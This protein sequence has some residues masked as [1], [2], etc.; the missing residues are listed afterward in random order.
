M[1]LCRS[2]RK[3]LQVLKLN[4][5]NKGVLDQYSDLRP[6]IWKSTRYFFM[7]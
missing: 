1:D 2:M 6:M 3:V 5:E 7:A 4:F